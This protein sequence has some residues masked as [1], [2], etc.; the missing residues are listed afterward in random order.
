MVKTYTEQ[1]DTNIALVNCFKEIEEGLN[2]LVDLSRKTDL[3]QRCVSIAS[4]H[5][6][7]G[8]CAL[9]RAIF[10]PQRLTEVIELDDAFDRAGRLMRERQKELTVEGTIKALGLPRGLSSADM[11]R[12]NFRSVV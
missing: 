5:F 10:K 2:R 12:A 11:D 7:E 1:S 3:D 4:T 9:N 6:M 8:F